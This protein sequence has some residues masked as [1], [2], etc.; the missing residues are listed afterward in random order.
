VNELYKSGKQLQD[1][2]VN[3]MSA[4]AQNLQKSAQGISHNTS[5]AAAVATLTPQIAAVHNAQSQQLDANC[6]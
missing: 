1:A 5:V 6:K 2:K 4:R 3:Q